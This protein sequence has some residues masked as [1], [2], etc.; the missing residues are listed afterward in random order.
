VALDEFAFETEIVAAL[1]EQGG[2]TVGAP[3]NFDPGR[4]IDTAELAAFIGATQ[5][6]AWNTLIELHGGDQ[7]TAQR[8]FYD[9]LA[10]ELDSRGTVDV[11][12]RGVVDLG[13]T[14]QLAYFRPAHGLTSVLVQRYDANR[15][16]VTRQLGYES[17]STKTVD[18]ALFVNGLP[19]AT[20]ELK[21]PLTGQTVEHAKAQ[22]RTERDP[23]RHPFR[24]GHRAG[25]H[26]HPAG[27]QQHE[28]PS[29]QPRAGWRRG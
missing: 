5:I 17:G 24:G 15:L 1:T 2:Y 18:L 11:L 27:R 6:E 10:K 21:N 19:V 29:V 8:A 25:R 23:R 16:T 20:A 3:V 9:R 22:Y 4:G 12:R 7:A 13:V 28:V 26:D 14:I